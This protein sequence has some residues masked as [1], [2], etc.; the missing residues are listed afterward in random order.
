MYI[1]TFNIKEEGPKVIEFSKESQGAKEL[2]FKAKSK[3]KK[4]LKITED[5]KLEEN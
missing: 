4:V 1:A 2:F 3:P 5:L